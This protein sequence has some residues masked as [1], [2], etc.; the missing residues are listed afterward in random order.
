MKGQ[1]DKGRVS[2]F[3]RAPSAA[4]I[5][6]N[7]RVFYRLVVKDASVTMVDGEISTRISEEAP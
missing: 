3:G 1:K 4:D 7:P 6:S 5:W 2:G